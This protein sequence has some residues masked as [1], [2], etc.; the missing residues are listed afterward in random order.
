L[1]RTKTSYHRV[2]NIA[3]LIT[4]S[5]FDWWLGRIEQHLTPVALL[6]EV[7]ETFVRV[8]AE[9]GSP[10]VARWSILRLGRRLKM[11]FVEVTMFAMIR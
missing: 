7:V 4:I 2:A 6:L 5:N 3:T 10:S 11:P 1:K 8:K 9:K